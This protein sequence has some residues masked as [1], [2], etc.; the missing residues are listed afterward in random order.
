[1]QWTAAEMQDGR[2]PFAHTAN[3]G[4]PPL[5]DRP[6][7]AMARRAVAAGRT[8]CGMTPA[9]IFPHPKLDITKH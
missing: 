1:M 8:N 5:P 9:A 2:V 7:L 4:R 3:A 6:W